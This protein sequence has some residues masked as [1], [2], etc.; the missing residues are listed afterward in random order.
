MTTLCYSYCFSLSD[1]RSNLKK[2]KQ[3]SIFKKEHEFQSFNNDNISTNKKWKVNCSLYHLNEICCSYIS[4]TPK[5]KQT[6][7][8]LGSSTQ[9]ALGSSYCQ[10]AL[11][12][13][14]SSNSSGCSIF[15]WTCRG[16]TV[17]K[18]AIIHTNVKTWGKQQH[19]GDK[20]NTGIR[21]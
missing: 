4:S 15:V 12:L 5:N 2:I 14:Y 7:W 21:K 1:L 19:S 8:R 3:K 10:Q 18:Q 17:L 13:L 11:T 16:V 20:Q 9:L 6:I